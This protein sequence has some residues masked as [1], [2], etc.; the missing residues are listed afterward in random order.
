MGDSQGVS[1]SNNNGV[2]QVPENSGA[3][4]FEHYGFITH[5]EANSETQ[6]WKLPQQFLGNKITSYGGQLLIQLQY[7]GS[8]YKKNEPFVI[9]KVLIIIIFYFL[10]LICLYL[11][12]FRVMEFQLCILH[13][14]K[15]MCL[16]QIVL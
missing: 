9:L 13:K 15:N 8:G 5:K 16:F 3:F 1:L 7:E 11:Y 14:I 10:N 12:I 2:E 6:Y 4:S